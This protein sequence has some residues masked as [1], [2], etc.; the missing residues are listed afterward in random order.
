M[1]H[2]IFCACVSSYHHFEWAKLDR[3]LGGRFPEKQRGRSVTPLA[4]VWL[5]YRTGPVLPRW[6]SQYP[7]LLLKQ[8][9]DLPVFSHGDK[10]CHRRA[11]SSCCRHVRANTCMLFLTL[12]CC[13]SDFVTTLSC[14]F[15][16][17]KRHKMSW[18]TVLKTYANVVVTILALI[19]LFVTAKVISREI[20]ICACVMWSKHTFPIFLFLPN[21]SI[22]LDELEQFSQ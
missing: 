4:G 8:P 10:N 19:M 22:P 2:L 18:I 1:T 9:A 7:L 20:P 11:S 14:D 15:G 21:P 16:L 13:R 3:G 12:C 6:A 5:C 17:R